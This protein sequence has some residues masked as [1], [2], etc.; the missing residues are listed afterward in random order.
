MDPF[1]KDY[2]DRLSELHH[3]LAATIDGLPIEALDWSPGPDI[4]SLSVLVAHTAGSER[5]WIG[6]VAGVDLAGSD[7][8]QEY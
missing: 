5:Y 1:F 2:Y 6:E 4:N 8:P 3:D 7:R